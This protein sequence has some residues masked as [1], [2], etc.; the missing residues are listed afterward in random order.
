MH[1]GDPAEAPM[2]GNAR[3]FGDE[4]GESSQRGFRCAASA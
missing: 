3:N 1:A 4:V 2:L